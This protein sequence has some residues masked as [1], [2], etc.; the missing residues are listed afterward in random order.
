MTEKCCDKCKHYYW[1]SDR[2]KKFDIEVD[3]RE[4][5]DCFERREE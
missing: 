2:C 3:D 4:I 1:Y 5:H